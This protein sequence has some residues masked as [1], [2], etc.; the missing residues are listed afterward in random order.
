M[1]N[2]IFIPFN[3]ASSKNSKRWTGK[4]LIG[5]KTTMEYKKNTALFWIRHKAQFLEMIKDKSKP[6]RI[7][8]YF[9]RDSKRKADFI[10]LA[11]L[12]LDLM[13]EYNWL[14]NDDMDTVLPVFTGYEVNK[15]KAG[16][17]ITILC[18]KFTN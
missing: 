14:E 7:G 16:V 1:T 6:Y 17:I 5:S 18:S 13:Q 8:F 2:Q 10:N 3:V 4:F 12:P 9:I 11:Q 15:E